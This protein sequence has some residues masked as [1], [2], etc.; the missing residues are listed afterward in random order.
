[1]RAREKNGRNGEKKCSKRKKEKREK[2]KKKE[3]ET[4]EEEGRR[5][6]APDLQFEFIT[7]NTGLCGWFFVITCVTSIVEL[8]FL[9]IFLWMQQIEA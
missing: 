3:S 9:S 6:N 1:L 4:R 8:L 7:I 5:K 2:G